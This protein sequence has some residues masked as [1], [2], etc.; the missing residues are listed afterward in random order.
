M[1]NQNY[2]VEMVSQI[3][4]KLLESTQAFAFVLQ[5]LNNQ[6]QQVCNRRNTELKSWSHPLPL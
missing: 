6:R 1:K 3:K 4:T 5:G 2:S